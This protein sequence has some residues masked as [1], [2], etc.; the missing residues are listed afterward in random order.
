MHTARLLPVSPGMHCSWGCT[1][2]WG[3]T[4][5]GCTWSGVGVPAWGGVPGPR[6]V[7]WSW[8]IPGPGG[9]YLVLGVYLFLEVYL[10]LYTWS[11]GIYLV[12]GVYLVL[13]VY[14]VPVGGPSPRVTWSQGVY[15]VPGRTCPG[16]PPP[17]P[18]E[19]ND[20]QTGVKI[21]PYPKLCLRVVITSISS[22]I[23]KKA[24][25]NKSCDTIF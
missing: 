3:C 12:L 10:V 23:N 19:Q 16:T 17:H 24:Y 4:C 2:S 25:E 11:L 5:W 1:W 22:C 7:T 6:A 8:G 14:L 15:Q 9:V 13:A 18:C 20:R 21:L